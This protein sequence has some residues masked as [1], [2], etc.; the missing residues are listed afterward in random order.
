MTTMFMRVF[1]TLNLVLLLAVPA[2][3]G[4]DRFQGTEQVG[5]TTV[6]KFV[7]KGSPPT[8]QIS[9]SN[10]L[11]EFGRLVANFG[12]AY[13][14]I[15]DSSGFV[16]KPSGAAT[17][18]KEIEVRNDLRQGAIDAHFYIDGQKVATSHSRPPGHKAKF[19]WKCVQEPKS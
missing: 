12:Q 16:L 14:V 18:P 7:C 17:S 19:G 13:H 5:G 9:A 1:L 2:L 8:F 4:D 11:N 3:A 6:I 15:L 10:D